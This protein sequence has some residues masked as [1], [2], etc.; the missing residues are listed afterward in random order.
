MARI[1]ARVLRMKYDVTLAFDGLEGFAAATAQP[2][3]DLI[4]TDVAMPGLDGLSL[5]RR[6]REVDSL[7]A[8]PIIMLTAQNRTA[9]IMTGS[10]PGLGAT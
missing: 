1:T 10:T 9:E 5:V 7:R 8:V 6:I 4:I 2:P 3:P